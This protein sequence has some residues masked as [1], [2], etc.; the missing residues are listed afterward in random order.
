VIAGYFHII[1]N[2]IDEAVEIAKQNPMFKDI[3][4]KN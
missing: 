1:A 3:P 4:T 2:D